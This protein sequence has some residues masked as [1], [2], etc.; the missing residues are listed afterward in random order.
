MR[1]TCRHSKKNA[2]HV[3]KHSAFTGEC[4]YDAIICL[5]CGDAHWMKGWREKATLIETVPIEAIPV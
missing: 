3:V 2:A 4:I 5:R 1:W